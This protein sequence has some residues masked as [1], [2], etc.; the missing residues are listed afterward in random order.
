MTVP[1][2]ELLFLALGGSGEIG[3]NANLYGCDGK[4]IMLDLG[5]SFGT[6]DYPGID[7]VMPDLEFIEDRRDNLLGIVLTHGHE[8]H[9][10]A[11]PYL[12]A[13]LGV[14]LYANRFTAGL[15]A[16]KLAEEGLEKE[17]EVR[18][19][20]IDARVE[21]GLLRLRTVPPAPSTLEL[22]LGVV[23]PPYGP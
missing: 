13:E 20:D 12:A 9:I 14:P 22:S 18:T 3:M 21:L 10:G 19:V 1:G 4:W 23:D 5:V 15:I 8:D 16:H 6:P 7:I 11:L 17:V 2:K